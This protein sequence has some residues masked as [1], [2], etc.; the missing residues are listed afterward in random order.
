MFKI[1]KIIFL[2][3]AAFSL[4]LGINSYADETSL[5][6][7]SVVNPDALIVLDLSGSMAWNPAGGNNIW[8]NSSCTGTFYSSSGSGH[9]YDCSRV[10][11][12]KRAICNVLDDTNNGCLD[13]DNDGTVNTAN[14]DT[15]DESSL[16][17]RI[18]YMRFYDG[19]YGYTA[20]DPERTEDLDNLADSSYTSGCNKIIRALNTTNKEIG[21]GGYSPNYSDIWSSVSGESARGGTPDAAALAE[22][23]K[24]LEDHKGED[25]SKACRKKFVVFITDGADTYACNGNGSEGQSDQYKRRRELV[26]RAKALADAGYKVFV[27]GFGSGMPDYLEKTLNWAAYY[28]GTDDP[29]AANSGSTSGYN[30]SSGNLYPSGVSS[31]STSTTSGGYATSNDPGNT[32]LSGY[33]FLAAD[34]DQL[35]AA[36]K[37]A[38]DI[39]RQANYSF[40]ASSVASVRIPDEN[41]IYEASFVQVN[42][43]P[44]WLGHLKKYHVNPNGSIGSLVTDW[45]G[46]TGDA[47][48]VLKG[49]SA[50]SRNILTYK[51][52]A[53]TAFNTTNITTGDLS[54]TTTCDRDLIVKYIRG[55]T[56]LPKDTNPPTCTISYVTNPDDWK[57]GDIFHSNPITIGTPSSFFNDTLDSTNAFSDFRCS[58]W[59]AANPPSGCSYLSEQRRIVVGA[60]D[61]QLHVFKT[62]DGSETWS[63]IPPN[64]LSRLKDIA[65]SSHPTGS[66]HQYFVDGPITVADVWLP[67][68]EGSGSTKSASEW[69]TLLVFGEGQ[70]GS[71]TLWSS[72]SSCD[73]GFSPT[74]SSTYQYYCGYYAF[75]FT[76]TTS[77]AY[78]WRINPTSSNAPYLAEPGSK[79][80]IGRVK[81]SGNE[82]WVGFI[83]GGYNASDCSGGG[84]CDERGKGFYVIDLSNGNVLYSYNC[85]K[86]GSN[87]TT[88]MKYS[89]PASPAIV[90][91]DNDG[92]IDTA[93]IG[94]LGGSVWRFKFCTKSEI[95]AG[96]C[97]NTS[98]WSGGAFFGATS[99]VIRPIYT[100]PTVAKDTSNNLW[101]YWGTGDKTDPTSTSA[102]EKFFALKDNDRTTS[103]GINDLENITASTYSG[104]K[105]GWYINLSGSG[106]KVLAEPTVFGGVV[107]FTT[108][109]PDPSNSNLCE[110]AGT[111]TLYGVNATTGSGV[112]GVID[113]SGS[114]SKTIGKGIASAPV[115]SLK[116]GGTGTPDLYVTLSGGS[117]VKITKLDVNPPDISNRTNILFWKD[118]RAQ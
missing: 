106:E 117:D 64:F 17:I 87:C 33:A 105:E 88:N 50:D 20:C 89:I 90:D 36:L 47:G 60:N 104:V 26:A 111:A 78:K 24:Y 30:I 21:Q 102:Q 29:D 79:M 57:L 35:S 99:G 114:R 68:S 61:G 112:I 58:H 65:H 100:T 31:C 1:N 97:T 69:K 95:T 38:F 92:F 16:K 11:I 2:F 109:T 72:S 53:L 40:S 37:K 13:T 86:S 39:I 70:G 34:A 3:F 22:A 84:S 56:T 80:V 41:Y 49:T 66:S 6:T 48:T 73:S 113:A 115:I 96:T 108:Y 15:S 110:R 76:T 101:V 55:E 54:V 27:V 51:S 43:D 14:I 63:F 45:G 25:N 75:D 19:T 74:Y 91:T 67:P 71:T 93:Y 4:F 81:I 85:A 107:Y 44:F 82:K 23:K 59:R 118:K 52:G 9:T 77:P 28:G 10:A 42:N 18:G 5:I 116:P 103:Y 8:G 7:L 12:A 46:V 32:T 94:D 98:H 83:G 62:S